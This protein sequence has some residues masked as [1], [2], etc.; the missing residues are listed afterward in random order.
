LEDAGKSTSAEELRE[1]AARQAGASI[2]PPDYSV[3]LPNAFRSFGKVKRWV[4]PATL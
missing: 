3:L 2:F 1:N 4:S